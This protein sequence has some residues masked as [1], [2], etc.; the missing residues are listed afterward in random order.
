M[1]IP[2][3]SIS[4]SNKIDPFLPSSISVIYTS[5][6]ASV[7]KSFIRTLP[8]EIMKK[9]PPYNQNAA[10]RSAL[11]RTFSR[12]PVVREV[13]GEVR[14]EV[15]KYNKDGSVAKKPSVQYQCS[16]C[17]QWVGST[18]ASVD[19]S[20][21]VICIDLGF[22]DWNIFV[23]RLF[24]PKENLQVLCSDGVSSCHQIKTNRERF[25]R[26][27]RAELNELKSFEPDEAGLKWLKKFTVKRLTS[28]E[29]PPEFKEI[30]LALRVKHLKRSSPKIE[31]EH[32]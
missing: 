6:A 10:I 22:V 21:P 1:A 29:Y 4:L 30:I 25:E 31:R 8:R 27:Y 28:F 7:C 20:T 15:A 5:P 23:D 12:S 24:C 11:R 13:M 14:R 2:Q 26:T 9:R 17:K 18:K 16:V 19:H 3:I 32:G